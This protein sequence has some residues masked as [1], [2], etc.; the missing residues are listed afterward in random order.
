MGTKPQQRTADIRRLQE[1]SRTIRTSIILNVALVVLKLAAGLVGHSA[2][3]LADAFHSLSDVATDASVLMGLR[4]SV[5]PS[6]QHHPYGHGKI[7]TL[8][9]LFVG[10]ALLGVASKIGYGGLTAIFKPAAAPSLF[11]LIAAGVSVLVKELLYRYTIAKGVRLSSKAIV[12]N[13]W[14]HRSDALSSVVAIIGVAGSMAGITLLDPLAATIVAVLIGYVGVKIITGTTGE[15]IDSSVDTKLVQ[16]IQETA[17]KVPG[18]I[19][20]HAVRARYVGPW[21]TTQ[22][23]IKV[24][25]QIS[26]EQ[27]HTIAH[28]VEKTIVAQIGQVHEVTVHVEPAYQE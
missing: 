25:P 14:H 18:V 27:S 23:H 20:V 7:E 2:A 21:V 12:A 5:R 17:N 3:L 28:Q 4:W 26:V 10:V 11:P 19:S 16:V 22:L 1:G 8:T 15:L 13:A 6:D 9:A 24:L